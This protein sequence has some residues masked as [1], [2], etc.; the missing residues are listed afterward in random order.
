MWTE[1]H[2]RIYRR[3]G[4]GYPSD[5]TDAEWTRL[6]ALIPKA[7]PGGRPGKSD[8]WAAMSPFCICCAPAAL[9]AICPT[10]AFCHKVVN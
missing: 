2:R 4:E 10:T 8:M 5:L 7:A 6:E 3:E 1:A 9:S